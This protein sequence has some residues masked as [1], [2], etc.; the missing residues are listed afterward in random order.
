VGRACDVSIL[1]HFVNCLHNSYARTRERFNPYPYQTGSYFKG[2]GVPKT[3][4]AGENSLLD[5]VY[6][7]LH[8][9]SAK[10]L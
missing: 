9:A 4:E 7:N 10:F 8:C 5:L 2:H 1:A 6:S 3:V